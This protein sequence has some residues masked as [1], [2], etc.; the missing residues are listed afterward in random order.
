MGKNRDEINNIFFSDLR[1][2]NERFYVNFMVL[3]PQ[4]SYFM[5]LGKDIDDTETFSF[6][7]LAL[8]NSKEVEILGITLNRSMGF[9]T[10]IR[11]ICRK[12]GHK[13]SALLRISPYIDQGKKI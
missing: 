4:K 8:K 2:V 5:C 3:N 11:N 1:L 9:N 10:H 7:D 13:I 6:N 12:A